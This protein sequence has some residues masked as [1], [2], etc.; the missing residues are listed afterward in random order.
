MHANLF[1]GAQQEQ[2][3]INCL[4]HNWNGLCPDGRGAFTKTK[5]NR[6][7]E[8]SDLKVREKVA[9]VMRNGL[10]SK[11]IQHTVESCKTKV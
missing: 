4:S 7:M 10:Q 1:A 8:L 3:V 9:S 11:Y 6:W 5:T 2:E